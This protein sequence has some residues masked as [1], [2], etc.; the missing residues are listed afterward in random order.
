MIFFWDTLQ[1]ITW[2]KIKNSEGHGGDIA[3]GRQLNRPARRITEKSL[4]ESFVAKC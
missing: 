2:K 4:A 3:F 1:H